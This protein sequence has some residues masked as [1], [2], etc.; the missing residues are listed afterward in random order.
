MTLNDI[1]KNSADSQLHAAIFEKNKI[2][3]S[4]YH[5]EL[6]TNV[7]ITLN[8]NIVYSTFED[9]HQNT[10]FIKLLHLNEHLSI[11]NGVYVPSTDFSEFMSEVR[12]NLSLAYGL[13]ASKYSLLFSLIGNFN[14]A[15]V[16]VD[17]N[18]ISYEIL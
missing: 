1:I 17:E 2:K 3:L 18:A 5:Y 16:L 6:D 15:A 13:R 14:L 4:F 12:A 9:T 8:S 7:N 11:R 10:F